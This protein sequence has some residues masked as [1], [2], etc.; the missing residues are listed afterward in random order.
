VFAFGKAAYRGSA[1]DASGSQ[2]TTGIAS[3][4]TGRGYWVLHANGSVR[5]FGDATPYDG[6]PAARAVAI[7][8]AR[9]G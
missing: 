4:W 5:G 1:A 7:Q 3:T 8:G 6:F 9:R 2:P